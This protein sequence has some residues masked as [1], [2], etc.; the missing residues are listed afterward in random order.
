MLRLTATA[1]S[2]YVR[3]QARAVDPS[4]RFAITRGAPACREI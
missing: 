3:S 1:R 4:R 2:V